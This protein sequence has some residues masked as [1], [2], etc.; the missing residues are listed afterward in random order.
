MIP[1]LPKRLFNFVRNHD[2]HEFFKGRIRKLTAKFDFFFIKSRVVLRFAVSYDIVVRRVGLY[3]DTARNVA[4]PGPS[5]S[6]REKLKGSFSG[7]VRRQIQETVRRQYTYGCHTGKVVTL[8]D[9]LRPQ[10]DVE[11]MPAKSFDNHVG[12]VFTLRRIPVETDDAGRRK[13]LFQLGFHLFR[14][15]TEKL[16]IFAAAIRTKRRND[17]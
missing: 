7:H 8:G 16:D 3:D 14:A 17:I 12:A 4:A 13:E 6:L 1:L 11:F 10:E 5:G 2:F 9:H 15:G